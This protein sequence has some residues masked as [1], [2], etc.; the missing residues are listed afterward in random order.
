M[1]VF[2]SPSVQSV[3][4]AATAGWIRQAG[5]IESDPGIAPGGFRRESTPPSGTKSV[6]PYGNGCPVNG[7]I[8]G[9]LGALGHKSTG[10]VVITAVFVPHGGGKF[11]GSKWP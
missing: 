1:I 9:G 5:T 10:T 11:F 4:R 6:S 7:W 3:S 8:R 2:D